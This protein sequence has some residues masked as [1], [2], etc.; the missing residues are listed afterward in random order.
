MIK[1]TEFIGEVALMAE[2]DYGIL[3]KD[4]REDPTN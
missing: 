1:G 2:E 4:L 3:R